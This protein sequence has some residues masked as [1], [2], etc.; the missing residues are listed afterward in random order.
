MDMHN[1]MRLYRMELR[2]NRSFFLVVIISELLYLA[3]IFSRFL[4]NYSQDPFKIGL[5]VHFLQ[6]GIFI[7]FPFMMMYS[8]QR[9]EKNWA[10][11]LPSSPGSTNSH[12][13][14]FPVTPGWEI[15]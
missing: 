8:W 6:L 1:S 9:E 2:K 4:F 5:T 13:K 15:R 12:W 7:A 10:T 3:A 14:R 11:G